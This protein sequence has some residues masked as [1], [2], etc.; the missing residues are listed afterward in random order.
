[1]N[2]KLQNKWPNH[3]LTMDSR[4]TQ[5][6]KNYQPDGRRNVGRLKRQWD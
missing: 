3:I 4:L 6:I 1:M 5:K 2:P